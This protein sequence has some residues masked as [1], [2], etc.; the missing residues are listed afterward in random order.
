MLV[1]ERLARASIFLGVM[2]KGTFVPRATGFL[3][4]Y[5]EEQFRFDHIITAEHV[6]VGICDSGEE[7]WCRA[8]LTNGDTAEVKIP[9][10]AW[11]FHP[12]D[13]CNT[14]IAVCPLTFDLTLPDG[15]AASLDHNVVILNGERGMAATSDVII[16]KQIGAGEEICIIG[17][18]RSHYGR[19][20]N[21]PI[22]RIGNIAALSNEPVLT[23]YK[24]FMKGYLVEARSIGGLS[25]SPVYVHIPPIRVFDGKISR[26]TGREFYLLGLMHG[27]FDVADLTHDVVIDDPRRG[28]GPSGIHSGIG[29]V[30]PVDLILDVIN[31]PELIAMRKESVARLVQEGAK[32]DLS[33]EPFPD[34]GN[35]PNPQHREDFKRLVGAAA[36]KRPPSDRT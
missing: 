19:Q 8:N 24:K 17:L 36:K 11:R 9:W 20:R 3:A 27:H 32:P 18:F 14:D 22:V 13:K 7:L 12:D 16:D 25:G 15:S 4:S 34:A 29:V 26:A 31:H 33:Q 21:I 6:I 30:I 1:P 35:E 5:E 2:S 23:Y 28:E 10:D